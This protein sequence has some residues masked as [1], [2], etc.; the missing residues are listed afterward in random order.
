MLSQ[1]EAANALLNA[2]P[3][4]WEGEALSPL[5]FLN[6][7]EGLHYQLSQTKTKN[8]SVRLLEAS[9]KKETWIQKEVHICIYYIYINYTPTIKIPSHPPFLYLK[10]D[11]SQLHIYEDSLHMRPFTHISPYLYGFSILP[12]SHKDWRPDR[13]HM[14]PRDAL[15]T[16]CLMGQAPAHLVWGPFETKLPPSKTPSSMIGF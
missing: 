7:L 4:L 15:T 14:F 10:G 12:P 11:M 6:L 1:G 9:R 2:N 3:H 5:L 16:D 13:G 8:H